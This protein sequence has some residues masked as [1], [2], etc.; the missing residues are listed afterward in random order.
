MGYF[1]TFM[2]MV[3]FPFEL[4]LANDLT[5]IIPYLSATVLNPMIE[6]TPSL[7]VSFSTSASDEFV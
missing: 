3:T 7:S 5:I 2:S 6:P 1:S 4:P